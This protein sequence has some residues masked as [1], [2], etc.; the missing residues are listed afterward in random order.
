MDLCT[1]NQPEKQVEFNSSEY[2]F[3][4]F[5]KFIEYDPQGFFSKSHQIWQKYVE[6]MKNNELHGTFK[7]RVST[8]NSSLL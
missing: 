7:T 2:F 5:L 8:W 3:F 6:E 1:Q 4:I